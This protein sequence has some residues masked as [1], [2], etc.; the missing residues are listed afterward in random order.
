VIGNG[1]TPGGVIE[2][3]FEGNSPLDMCGLVVGHL[4]EFSKVQSIKRSIRPEVL[5]S[6]VRPVCL[7]LLER[8][9]QPVNLTTCIRGDSTFPFT[10]LQ[11][12]MQ[13]PICQ[14]PVD[15]PQY[16]QRNHKRS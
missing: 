12:R 16:K 15:I 1:E 6:C 4:V 5:L 8:S 3:G 11:F 10:S 2:R 14:L 7:V 13:R 9:D